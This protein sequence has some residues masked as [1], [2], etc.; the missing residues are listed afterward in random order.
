[1]EIQMNENEFVT[2]QQTT[3]EDYA[4]PQACYVPTEQVYTPLP[5]TAEE[6]EEMPEAVRNIY[7]SKLN[8]IYNDVSLNI[9]SYQDANE[10][11][12]LYDDIAYDNMK[13]Q[14]YSTITELVDKGLP[15]T[16][17][18]E[19]Y[20]NQKRYNEAYGAGLYSA[21]ADARV[22]GQA[23]DND[24]MLSAYLDSEDDSSELYTA[25]QNTMV[26]YQALDDMVVKA[27]ERNNER[28]IATKMAVGIGAI[29][30]FE[31]N[32]NAARILKNILKNRLGN[33][34][35][36][37][38]I[39]DSWNMNKVAEAGRKALQRAA[40]GSINDFKQILND[41]DQDLLEEPKLTL[42]DRANLWNQIQNTT[43]S[44][45]RFAFG[46]EIVGLLPIV[47]SAA[48]S[49]RVA[50]AT[51]GSAVK[52]VSKAAL[53]TAK[54][55]TS[56]DVLAGVGKFV[57]KPLQM[58]RLTGRKTTAQANLDSLL[59]MSVVERT[60]DPTASSNAIKNSSKAWLENGMSGAYSPNAYKV[61]PSLPSDNVNMLANAM[62]G[63]DDAQ[64]A[65]TAISLAQ[66]MDSGI[67]KGLE[68]DIKNEVLERFTDKYLQQK[69]NYVPRMENISM[70]SN[71]KGFSLYT[72]VG[73][74]KNRTKPFANVKSAQKFADELNI[75]NG[76][77]KGF[78]TNNTADVVVDSTGAYVR[79]QRDFMD[80]DKS[81]TLGDL[82]SAAIK[83]SEL[84]GRT[85]GKGFSSSLVGRY[86]GGANLTADYTTRVLNNL[87]QADE[88]R[89]LRL[90]NPYFKKLNKVSRKN[91]VVLDALREETA[92][93]GAYFTTTSLK[94]AGITDDVI[95]GY[96]A[97]KIM[98][99]ASWLTKMKTTSEGMLA[100]D[101][102]NI[103]F[104]V[105]RIGLGKIVDRPD[106]SFINVVTDVVNENG[107]MVPKVVKT[108][109][110]DI[111]SANVTFV[112]L[113][114]AVEGDN[115]IAINNASFKATNPSVMDT[116]F[117]Y[118][119]GRR[120]FS[121][122]SGFVK[123]VVPT[124]V[125]LANGTK[126]TIPASIRTL[127]AHP[128][129]NKVEEAAETLEAFRQEAI[130]VSKGKS[131][132]AAQK[133]I[134]KIKN[135]EA[136]GDFKEFYKLTQGDDALIS[137][138]PD[139]KLV[140]S[141]DGEKIMFGGEE[142]KDFNF[143]GA[144]TSQYTNSEK[145]LQKKMRSDNEIF[146]PFNFDEAPRLN[147]MEEMTIAA[148]NM[149][150]YST[151]DEYSRLYA[152]DFASAFGDYLDK[153]ASNMHNLL[154]FNAEERGSSIPKNIQ[155]QIS[156]AQ[157]NYRRMM[158]TNTKWDDWLESG[159]GWLADKL[160]PDLKN[161]GPD[162]LAF[163]RSLKNANPMRK[164]K[165]WTFNWF[166][167]G[168]NPKQLWTQA[169]A[170][171]NAINMHPANGTY[172]TMYHFPILAYMN[173]NDKSVL[174]KAVETFKL[175][176]VKELQ[177]VADIAK[178]LDVFT[179]AAPAGAFELGTKEAALSGTSWFDPSSFYLK[180]EYA[181]RTFT[182]IMAAKEA[183]DKGFR[184]SKMTNADFAN[185]V[186]RQQNLYL[187]MGRAGTS[188]LQ[189]GLPG[190]LTQFRGYQMR[191]LESMLDGELTAAEKSK[192]LL[193]QAVFGGFKGIVGG[194]YAPKWYASL[195]STFSDET[196]YTPLDELAYHGAVDYI[197][198]S[199]GN[200]HS[201]GNAWSVGL[202]DLFTLALDTSVA[203]MPPAMSMFSKPVGF[204]SNMYKEF[205][206]YLS[207]DVE[208]KKFGTFLEGLAQTTA[209]K[210]Q[211]PGGI[212]YLLAGY[213][214]LKTGSKLMYNGQLSLRSQN[215]MDAFLTA[216][217]IR[218]ISD[219][220]SALILAEMN[221]AKE[222]KNEQ[223][224]IAQEMLGFALNAPSDD[225]Q[226]MRLE[227]VKGMIGLIASEDPELAN[228]IFHQVY[229]PENMRGVKQERYI[230]LLEN[231]LPN[232]P[233]YKEQYRKA[234]EDAEARQQNT[235]EQ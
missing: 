110:S 99:D 211:L 210:K 68:K 233:Y 121:Q 213:Y 227:Q 52:G 220:Q 219:D 178:R 108:S 221:R 124:S 149:A 189:R 49:G 195:N 164:A 28:N 53:Q 228:N 47:K 39:G 193:G 146:N 183:Y 172:T 36:V 40:T 171:L 194:K 138:H 170:S 95:E 66:A 6:Q 198:M 46:A 22:L 132:A 1:M 226:K 15:S 34:P 61:V 70:V 80:G 135:W 84:A 123:Q 156:N 32:W 125:E 229:S 59:K 152:D 142:V 75:H 96:R 222:D 234:H 130:L 30:P 50:A 187:N 184:A 216:A 87:K 23:S 3:S 60:I 29:L 65:A 21:L 136:V 160:V 113:T 153:N 181:N 33:D 19:L 83:E 115:L 158:S 71:D 208:D 93:Q 165:A 81:A 128:A 103:N 106:R 8:E 134:Q 42:G 120:L 97:L 98:D 225:V 161:A 72:L 127:F 92:K 122:G 90:F 119:P 102:K 31:Q 188:E 230:K 69:L 185:L 167:S 54:M 94:K 45:N 5:K 7:N 9:S 37:Q 179:Q 137:L 140:F 89:I 51:S 145:V 223:K 162:K 201:F 232:G 11:N 91:G 76:V 203:D 63:I 27:N 10:L 57:S 205:M 231:M 41:I 180:G 155:N 199:M 85:K 190:F 168:Y 131:M 55:A 154:Y 192:L 235:I 139:A 202:G 196:Q 214:T 14:T 26:N 82:V 215:A 77:Y 105:K 212:S 74:G 217:G 62:E 186:V 148:E 209:A 109:M 16:M 73:T 147:S 177:E 67:T 166:L 118:K 38:K 159:M 175:G 133:D 200:N 141:R 150:R 116:M 104:G 64:D 100:N 88:G 13:N 17:A 169:S 24:I 20:N 174:R 191:F 58:L 56:A 206:D 78:V 79:I 35:D 197:A 18:L 48:T 44:M 224:R 2:T 126:K 114:H 204:M 111:K 117:S 86:L 163:Y 129:S 182:A 207:L 173:S 4:L 143:K 112:K 101:V 25:M 157:D 12:K 151:I 176:N 43:V 144:S 218:D 107:E